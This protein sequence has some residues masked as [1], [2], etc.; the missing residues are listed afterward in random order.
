MNRACY[1]S[2]TY[3]RRS[4]SASLKLEAER[5]LRVAFAPYPRRSA[6]ASLKLREPTGC[7]VR[8]RSYPRRSASASLKH[9]RLD[10]WIHR[11]RSYPR[12]SASASLKLGKAVIEGAPASTLSE[13]ISL[14]LIEAPTETK[15][16]QMGVDLSEAIS[17]GLIEACMR[18]PVPARSISLIRGDQPR[19]H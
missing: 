13:A 18:S 16:R 1:S 15:C 6:S 8:F 7:P 4:A 3:P 11:F 2:D 5:H 10:H 19:P 9:G 12:R 14:G 17:L